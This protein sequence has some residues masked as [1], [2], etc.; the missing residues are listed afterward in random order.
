MIEVSLG[1]GQQLR[2]QVQ[3]YDSSLLAES[4]L[5]QLLENSKICLKVGFEHR[6]DVLEQFGEA[7]YLSRLVVTEFL[8]YLSSFRTDDARVGLF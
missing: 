5:V 2:A 1:F 8:K 7:L 4:S 6:D 3:P